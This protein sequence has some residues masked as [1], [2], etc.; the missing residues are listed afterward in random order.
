[1]NIIR[2]MISLIFGLIILLT[3]CN[4][5]P[6]NEVPPPQSSNQMISGCV[7]YYSN[8]EIGTQC[9]ENEERRI[10]I[11]SQKDF[12]KVWKDAFGQDKP[13]PT[14]AKPLNGS[15]V[16]PTQIDFNKGMVFVAFMGKDGGNASIEVTEME[17]RDSA[18]HITVKLKHSKEAKVTAPYHF[19]WIHTKKDVS[20]VF[21]TD[22]E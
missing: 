21:V 5:S 15:K 3:G 16:P 8:I 12:E 20:K 1:M 6:N 18:F 19:T 17:P 7:K 4:N 14:H 11:T 9:N 13:V 22:K 2:I 10:L